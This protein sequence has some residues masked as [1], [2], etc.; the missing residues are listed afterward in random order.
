MFRDHATKTDPP[1]ARR[2]RFHDSAGNHSAGPFVAG[3]SLA[4]QKLPGHKKA[5]NR[6]I[7][8]YGNI[9]AARLA[10]CA[11]L[12][13]TE[14][15]GSMKSTESAAIQVNQDL[16][17]PKCKVSGAAIWEEIP[18]P[19][20]HPPHVRFEAGR[21]EAGRARNRLRKLVGLTA[22]FKSVDKGD[23]EGLTIACADCGAA[24]SSD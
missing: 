4:P 17:C 22:G 3:V 14:G 19:V 10:H 12:N 2:A 9:V 21:F 18:N 23:R 24:I 20:A 1:K 8:V 5:T 13:R 15:T 7:C 11:A 16:R 6:K